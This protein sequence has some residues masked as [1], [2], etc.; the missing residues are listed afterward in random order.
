MR[1]RVR[2]TRERTPRCYPLRVISRRLASTHNVYWFWRPKAL[3]RKTMSE[4]KPRLVLILL[5]AFAVA[6]VVGSIVSIKTG[7][8]N[9]GW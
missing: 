2:S 1:S 5:A 9:H 3:W 8:T 6:Q 7:T 4:W